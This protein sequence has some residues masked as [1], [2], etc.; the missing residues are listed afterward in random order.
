MADALFTQL[1]DGTYL[2]QDPARGPWSRGS[3]HGGPV[4]ALVGGALEPLLEELHPARVTVEF[5]RPVPMKPLKLTA[6]VTQ[7]G[8]RVRRASVRLATK[9]GTLLATGT[10]VGIRRADLVVP[11]SPQSEPPP[12]LPAADDDASQALAEDY[13]AF[14]N[15]G[16]RHRYV[17]GGFLE[18]GPATDWVTFGVPVVEGLEPTP[19]QRVM[20][21]S[22]CGNGISRLATFDEMTF[23][24]PD[25]T[26]HL[27]RLPV[28]EWI[29]LEAATVL[30]GHGI[31][32]AQSALWDEQGPLGRALQSLLVEGR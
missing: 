7:P 24:N 15:T 17:R 2:P 1:D 19:L 20:G 16:V 13:T 25:L 32:L 11:A 5:L 31:G 27:H 4:A 21:A 30:E 9:G 10:A 22:D 3:L 23:I 28:G 12:P 6:E 26:V 8:S 18:L 14:H 29:A